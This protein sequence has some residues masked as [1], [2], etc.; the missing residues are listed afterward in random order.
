MWSAICIEGEKKIII[1]NILV[2]ALELQSKSRSAFSGPFLFVFNN[3]V[4]VVLTIDDDSLANTR[5]W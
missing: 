5:D 4:E 2:V 3:A 1:I